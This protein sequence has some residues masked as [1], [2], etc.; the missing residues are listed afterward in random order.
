MLLTRA[1]LIHTRRCFIVRLACVRPAANVRSEPG[2]NSP[3]EN[4]RCLTPSYSVP[5]TRY[6]YQVCVSLCFGIL[7]LANDHCAELLRRMDLFV[8]VC[9]YWRSTTNL[10]AR[11]QSSKQISR[12]QF[13]HCDELPIQ[14][15]KS[16]L[17][18]SARRPLFVG[19]RF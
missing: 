7:I 6:E 14:F 3:V 15:S 19:R 5:L 13:L 9:F 12:A 17:N 10:A 4:F 11:I 8:F 2:S 1:P 16:E 18:T